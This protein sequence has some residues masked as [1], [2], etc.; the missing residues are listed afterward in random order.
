MTKND[1]RIAAFGILLTAS[2]SGAGGA[3]AQAAQSGS[4]PFDRETGEWRIGWPGRVAKHDLVYLTPPGDPTQGIPLG[5][6]D[7]GVLCWT[8]GSKLILALNK[9]N[10]WDDAAFGRFENWAPGQEDVSTAL[11]HAGRLVVDF[12][13]PVFDPFYLSDFEARLSLAD[14]TLRVRA[15]GPFGSVSVI[16][17]V[18]AAR[19]AHPVPGEERAPRKDAAGSRLGTVREPDL[20][21]LVSPGESRSR[22]RAAGHAIGRRR[23]PRRPHPPADDRDL[24]RRRGR[25]P[26]RDHGRPGRQRPCRGPG[27]GR[28]RSRGIPARGRRHR[29]FAGGRGRRPGAPPPGGAEAR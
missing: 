27:D 25:A 6:G 3:V 14:A 9:S 12:K 17:R 2:L 1:I 28:R 29:S 26:R 20:L 10:L 13:L 23:G 16:L 19:R 4:T 22:N 5:S 21:P 11:R 24:R 7:V 8:E 15:A 18:D